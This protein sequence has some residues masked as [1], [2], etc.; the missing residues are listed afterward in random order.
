[1]TVN[2]ANTVSAL[3]EIMKKDT[4][5]DLEDDRKALQSTLDDINK[6]GPEHAK[7]V[8]DAM[9]DADKKQVMLVD[10]LQK[11]G[12]TKQELMLMPELKPP[13]PDIPIGPGGQKPPENSG[14]VPPDIGPDGKLPHMPE[15]IPLPNGALLR[16]G[17]GA[18]TTPSQGDMDENKRY[19]DAVTRAAI[20]TAR[21]VEKTQSTSQPETQEKQGE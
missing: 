19:L 14:I 15:A 5:T 9:S 1:M 6:Q 10:V 12:T 4:G 3:L 7:K 17:E 18:S 11:D 8:Y 13:L 16:P 21:E 2:E 20:N